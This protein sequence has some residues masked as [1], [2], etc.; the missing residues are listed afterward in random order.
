MNQEE[1]VQQHEPFWQH[2]EATL[3]GVEALRRRADAPPPGQLPEE[4]RRL[5]QHL[6]LAR[7]RHYATWL[8][9]RLNRLV[10]RGHQVLYEARAG[11]LAQAWHFFAAGFP[12]LV[13]SQ[14]RYFLLCSLLFYGPFL[15]MFLTIQDSPDMVYT[16]L[17][18][19]QV[20]SME[21][22]YDPSAPHIGRERASDGDFQMFGYYIWNNIGVSFRTFATGLAFGLGSIFFLVFN[23]LT[24]G[25]V[26]GHLTHLGFGSTFWPFVVG[27]GSFELTA[28]V[29]SGM[30]GMRMGFAILAPGRHSRRE[31]LR[32][33]AME[34]VR[35]MY[36][37]IVMLVIAAFLEAF[38]SSSTLLTSSVKFTVGGLLWVVVLSYLAFMGHRR[39]T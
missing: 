37:V 28:I 19:R 32:L 11:L 22:M 30:A 29:L 35:I 12:L 13:R 1:F 7:D 38:W 39:A 2:M 17:D 25:S 33:A 31:S 6:A 20:R 10:L 27:H 5:C 4:Y 26:A 16:V 23:G 18:H 15:A 3:T 24:I 34:A 36:G 21:R 14:W 8:V 9:E